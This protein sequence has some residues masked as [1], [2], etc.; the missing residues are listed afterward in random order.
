LLRPTRSALI[1]SRPPALLRALAALS[2][3]A[4]SVRCRARATTS[5]T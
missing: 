4:N 3:Y 1:L 5:L 2:R